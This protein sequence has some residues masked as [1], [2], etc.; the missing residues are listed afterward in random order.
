MAKIANRVFVPIKYLY[1]NNNK[2][3]VLILILISLQMPLLAIVP[4]SQK[5]KA[6]ITPPATLSVSDLPPKPNPIPN[7]IYMNDFAQDYDGEIGLLMLAYLQHIG[8]A[9]ISA[10]IGDWRY[11]QAQYAIDGILSSYNIGDVP[12]GVYN[13]AQATSGEERHGYHDGQLN[14]NVTQ[15]NREYGDSTNVLRETLNNATEQLTLVTNGPLTSLNNLIQSAAYNNGNDDIPLTGVEL[16]QQH[17]AKLIVGGGYYFKSPS[18]SNL[19]IAPAEAY[20]VIETWNSYLSSKPIIFMGEDASDAQGRDVN[21]PD[22]LVNFMN[23]KLLVGENIWPATNPAHWFWGQVPGEAQDF[24]DDGTFGLGYAESHDL[25]RTFYYVFGESV[26]FTLSE[27]C[28]NYVAPENS[29]DGSEVAGQTTC[30]PIEGVNSYFIYSP[31]NQDDVDALNDLVSRI[32]YTA[33]FEDITAPTT[34]IAAIPSS[35]DGS[36][37]WHK[38][39]APTVSLSANDGNGLGVD[40]IYY[41]WDNN[42]YQEYSTSLIA[43]EGTHTLYYYSNDNAGNSEVAKN[44]EFKVDTNTVTATITTPAVTTSSAPQPALSTTAPRYGQRN[45]TVT[46][47]Q[48]MLKQMGYYNKS[49]PITGYYGNLTRTAVMRYQKAKYL[50]INGRVDPATLAYLNYNGQGYIFTKTLKRGSSGKDVI[51]LQAKLKQGRFMSRYITTTGYFGYYTKIAVKKYQKAHSLPKTGIL[52]LA[53]RQAI[54]D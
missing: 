46:N 11:I 38:S 12:I 3:L 53:T 24:G 21:D 42:T 22:G 17:V 28:L 44:R 27:P 6:T 34:T 29:M 13:L 2:S 36:D 48:T 18:W 9:K 41:K 37:S 4:F 16:M 47:L 43:P 50:Q 19:M 35:P 5:A 25:I 45:V 20:N 23:A 10:V 32:A 26:Y 54:N 52:D 7:I 14:D 39:A 49:W 1:T 40:R 31:I 30:T 15:L 51:I 8:Y 33:A